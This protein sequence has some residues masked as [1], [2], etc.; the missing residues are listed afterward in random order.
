M[1]ME[2]TVSLE[3]ETMKTTVRVPSLPRLKLLTDGSRESK[4]SDTNL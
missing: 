2:G 3:G 4:G 1:R